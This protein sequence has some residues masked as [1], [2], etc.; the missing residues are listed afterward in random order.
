MK[1]AFL[2]W[3]I[4]LLTFSACSKLNKIRKSKDPLEKYQAAINYYEKKE[5][6]N[7]LI[8]LEEIEPLLR[9]KKEG[10]KAQFVVANCYYKLKQ[11]EMASYNF[12]RFYETY[13]RSEWAEESL[14]FHAYALYNQSPESELDQTPTLSAIQS[15]QSYLNSYPQSKRIEEANGIIKELRSKLELKAYQN[16]LLFYNTQNYKAAI[17]SLA[18]FEKD[19]SDS[20]FIEEVSYKKFETEYNLARQSIVSKK[21]ARFNEAIVFYEEYKYKY[22]N[23]KYLK[24]AKNLYESCLKQIEEIKKLDNP[25]KNNSENQ[26]RTPNSQG[27]EK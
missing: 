27:N 10:E 6:N 5:Y 7:T 25:N 26:S 12:K 24:D 22:P 16:A 18:N 19:Y 2:V 13:P 23:G 21:I 17:Q 9:G 8:L 4:L 15:I 20:D 11:Y 1:K 14:Y 3:V